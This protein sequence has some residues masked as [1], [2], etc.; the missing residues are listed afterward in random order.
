MPRHAETRQLPYTPEQ[1]FDLVADVARYGEFLPWVSA[2]RVRSD[3]ETEMVADLIV[4]FKGLRETFSSR[5][6]KQRPG[7]IRVDYLEGPLKHLHN[8][9]KFRSDGEGGVLIDFEVDFTFK[10]RVFEMLAG[11]VFDRALRMMINA[12]EQRA[13][14]LYGD[15]S[16]GTAGSPGS[17]SSSAHSAA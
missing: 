7:H 17:S 10:S 13:A 9:W 1:M 5:V 15:S 14:A 8:D 12:F 11:Q 3:S 6:T 16:A 4:G 2:V